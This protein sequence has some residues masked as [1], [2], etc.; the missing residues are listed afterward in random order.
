MKDSLGRKGVVTVRKA[1]KL[2]MQQDLIAPD[3]ELVDI[4]D[5]YRRVLSLNIVS[6]ENLPGFNRS[7]M[8]GYAVR[9]EKEI[10]WN[11]FFVIS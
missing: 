2:L 8:D 3:T 11:L 6:P 4:E 9:V 5:A 7:T 10:T 1:L